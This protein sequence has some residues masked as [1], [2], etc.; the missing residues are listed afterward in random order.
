MHY[1]DRDCYEAF[2]IEDTVLTKGLK[3]IREGV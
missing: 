1:K 3:Q 2:G